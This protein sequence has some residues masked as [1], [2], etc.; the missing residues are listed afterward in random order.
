MSYMGLFYEKEREQIRKIAHEEALA[1]FAEKVELEKERIENEAVDTVLDGMKSWENIDR[2]VARIQGVSEGYEES[3][4]IWY[5]DWVGE[6]RSANIN[7]EW[8][9]EKQIGNYFGT[10]EEAEKAVEKLKAWKRLKDKG[11]K[12]EGWDENH[13]N[14]GIIEFSF[15]MVEKNVW[16]FKEDLD[17]LFGD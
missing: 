7:N 5:I 16:E 17:L 6:I 4:E 8:D 1:V 14:L 9:G 13:H 2:T 10:K 11:F 15:D 3:D 12:V